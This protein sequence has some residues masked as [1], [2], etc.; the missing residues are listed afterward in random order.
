MIVASIAPALRSARHTSPLVTGLRATAGRAETRLRGALVT[1]QIALAVVLLAE[2]ALVGRSVLKLTRV[3]PGF[4]MNGLVAGRLSLP[5][6][7]DGRRDAVAAAVDRI[8]ERV[9]ATPGIIGAEAINQLPLNGAGN[10]G[11]FRIVGRATTDSTNPMIRDVTTGYFALMRIPL[12]EGRTFLPSDT[13]ASERVVAINRTLARHYFP[14][15]DAIGHRIVFE[16]FDGRPEW[17]IVGV[18]GDEQFGDL[19]RPMSPVVYF[20]FAQDPEP[21]FSLV[22]R[23]SSPGSAGS[24]MRAAV[25]AVD[26]E[27]PLY[28][29]RTLEQA[30]SESNAMFLRAI[31][32]RLL[33]WFSLAALVLGGVGVYGVLSEAMTARTREIGV[34]MALGATRGGIARLVLAAGAVPALAGLAAGAALTAAAAPALRSL[35]FGVTLLDIPS[36]AAVAGLLGAVTLLACAM[37][38]WRAVRLPVTTALRS[39]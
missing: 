10:T 30:A 17:T 14:D 29:L 4:E 19:D 21:A 13:R 33:A 27:L 8:L 7:Y 9:R 28:G 12:F 11:D 24:S 37:P 20:P 15:G 16:F 34:R 36:L 5:A 26:P 38:A 35:L 32:T 31:V 3:S 23:A 2:A 6:R 22:V 18:V 39:E 25:A 1:A